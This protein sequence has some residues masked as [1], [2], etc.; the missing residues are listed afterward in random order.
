MCGIAGIVAFKHGG[1]DYL[2]KISIAI[3]CLLHRGPDDSGIYI[4][5]KIALGHRRLS[6]ID[7]SHA[8]AQ[9]MSDPTGRFQIIFNGEFF[10]FNE[11]RKVL[12]SKGVTFQT[13]SDTEVL[14]QLYINEGPKALEKV[15]G[16]FAFAIYDK[17]EQTLFIA[18]DRMGVK[19]LL[20]FYDEEK[21]FFA[22]EM[23]ALLAMGI[24]KELDYDAMHLYFQLNYLPPDVSI[25][26]RVRKLRPGAFLFIHLNKEEEPSENLYYTIQDTENSVMD[27]P[28]FN[29]AENQIASLLDASVQRRMISDVPLGAFLSGGLDSSI[30]V[31]L[32]SQHVTKLNTFSIGFTDEPH[33][34]ETKYAEIVAHR[35]KTNHHTFKLSGNDM[36]QVLFEML[37]YLDEPFADSSALNVYILCKETRRKVT[38]ALSGD[39]ADEI[40]GGYQKHKAEWMLRNRLGGAFI[41]RSLA[42]I[43]SRL[44]G[45][46]QG[47]VANKLRQLQRFSQGAEL[48]A[49]ERYWLWCSIASKKETNDLLLIP[50][51]E[52]YQYIKKQYL[53]HID[54]RD[55]NSILRTDVQLVLA[56]D[57]LVKVDSMSMANSLEVRNPFL[58]KEVVNYAFTLSS[59][60]KI[61]GH[62]QKK[63]IRN[64]FSKIL[65]QEIIH[66]SKKGFE[67]PLLSWFNN[68]LKSLIT[69]DLLE[70]GFIVEQGLFNVEEVRRLKMQL[71]SSYPGDAAARI[72][73]LIVFQY[74]YRKYFSNE[75]RVSENRH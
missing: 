14:L 38:V 66:R 21:L 17:Q 33:F 43:I 70:D 34:D 55:M 40:F 12:V 49:D 42:P 73:A 18:R 39:G 63:I 28:S 75:D 46:R 24:P 29:I 26:K 48:S 65:P 59:K 57:M 51:A 45:S 15:N 74:W 27:D 4:D 56:G 37:D 19:P 54:A 61:D 68:E 53:D 20:Y 58:D 47:I 25:F 69:D 35:F 6:I 23:K 52:K 62:S 31:A 11:H 10:N 50:A 60:Y 1:E 44:K 30:V 64:A 5:E 22:S 32:A 13:N 9:P 2:R 41:L 36:L 7:I 72:W 16:F 8:A 71:F 67:V 3:H